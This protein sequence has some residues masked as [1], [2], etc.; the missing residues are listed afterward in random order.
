MFQCTDTFFFWRI[1]CK[2]AF[3]KMNLMIRLDNHIF[4]I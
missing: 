2:E 1:F 4:S 3:A